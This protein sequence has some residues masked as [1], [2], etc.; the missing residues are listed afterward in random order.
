MKKIS[1]IEKKNKI[2]KINTLISKKKM[3]A[4]IVYKLKGGKKLGYK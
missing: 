4:M 2:K 1:E 3:R